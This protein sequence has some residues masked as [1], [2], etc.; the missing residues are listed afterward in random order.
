AQPRPAGGARQQAGIPI[1]E[2]VKMIG[3]KHDLTNLIW[4]RQRGGNQLV[5]LWEG[6]EARVY[7]LTKDGLRPTNRNFARLFHEG[8]FAGIW[9]GLMNVIISFALLLLTVTGAWQFVTK[10]I[11]KYRNRRLKAEWGKAQAA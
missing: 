8:N 10:Q 6:G 4:L 3:E 2:A 7:A 5:R 1:A 9:S 11:R